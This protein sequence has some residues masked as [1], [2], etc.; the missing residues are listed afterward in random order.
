MPPRE[1]L[2]SNDPALDEP[3]SGNRPY[4]KAMIEAMD[5][6][7]GRLLDHIGP[8]VLEDTYVIFIGDNGTGGGVVGEPFR[9]GAAKGSVYNGGVAV[10][11]LIAGPGVAEGKTSYAL[12]NSTDLYA[13]FLE[14]AGIDM[15]NAVPDGVQLDSVSLMP[16]MADPDRDSTRE[17]IYADAFTTDLGVKSGEYAI[18]GPRYKFLVDQ[19]VEHFFD[20]EVDPYEHTNLLDSELSNTQLARYESLK[21]QVETLHAS[22][23]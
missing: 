18:R 5:T 23:H 2:Q 21:E 15:N 3:G 10:P 8:D 11:F 4:F 7:I 9:Q 1:L 17:W 19:S 6:E 12:A 16:Y 13:T 22:E 20:L 14:M